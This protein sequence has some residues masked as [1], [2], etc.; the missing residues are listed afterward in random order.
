MNQAIPVKTLDTTNK[1]EFKALHR[2]SP[3]IVRD[4]L[5]NHPSEGITPEQISSMFGSA[6]VTFADEV[7]PEASS[8]SSSCPLSEF[9]NEV[10]MGPELKL[11]TRTFSTD[12]IPNL[13]D[14]L[15]PP[16]FCEDWFES[17]LSKHWKNVVVATSNHLWAF[18]GQSG[19]VSGLHQDHNG[20]HTTLLQISGT[21]EVVL[22]SPEDSV[23]ICTF[24]NS[25]NFNITKSGTEVLVEFSNP[26]A[27]LNCNNL[28]PYYGK[29]HAGE[30]LYL[31]YRW[32]HFVRALSP[33]VTLSR[34]M[35]DERNVDF[36]FS[37]F[38]AHYVLEGESDTRRDSPLSET[39]F[40]QL[41]EEIS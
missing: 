33:S 6:I 17:C 5:K 13:I 18:I 1:E 12:A 2:D 8:L 19:C 22:F 40:S 27:G 14:I 11:G 3:A 31:P 15:P 21:K 20:V 4:G 29:L 36:Y 39:S 26:P 25:A 38:F 9:L 16:Y 7:E 30:V 35:I 24:D 10:W 32:G 23:E 34:D 41:M 28:Q 37:S